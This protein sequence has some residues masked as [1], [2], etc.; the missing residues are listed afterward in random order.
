MSSWGTGLNGKV[1]TDDHSPLNGKLLRLNKDYTLF[2]LD[3]ESMAVLHTREVS[4]NV[5]VMGLDQ[6]YKNATHWSG[7]WVQKVL[8]DGRIYWVDDEAIEG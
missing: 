8:F 7:G 6:R 5:V 2:F 4:K 1:E 3:T